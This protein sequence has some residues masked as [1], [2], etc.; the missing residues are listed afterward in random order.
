MCLSF[1]R[2]G[3]ANSCE[4]ELFN[5]IRDLLDDLAEFFQV[6]EGVRRRL[7]QGQGSELGHPWPQLE[8]EVMRYI[9]GELT[10]EDYYNEKT[11]IE[12]ASAALPG[13]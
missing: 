8:G 10:R 9:A 4:N 11:L 7:R 6:D 1:V 5:I 13:G 12:R 3:A 2:K